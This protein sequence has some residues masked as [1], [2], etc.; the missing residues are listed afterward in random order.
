MTFVN[1]FELTNIAVILC[2]ESSMKRK[3]L[4]PDFFDRPTLVVAKEL[5]GKFLVRRISGKEMALMIT[6]TESY[7][8][9]K[10]RASKGSR[11]QTAGNAPMFAKAG[12]I[13]VYFTYGMH[14]MLN[15]AT[16]EEGYPGAVLIRGGM[17]LH[18][19]KQ[20]QIYSGILEN[21]RI[22]GPARLTKK[23]QI[24]KRLNA[25]TLHKKVGLWIEDRGVI[26]PSRDIQRTPRIGIDSAGSPWVEKKYR[27]VL[28][29]PS[30][31]LRVKKKGPSLRTGPF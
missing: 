9:Y 16:R 7:D 2:A 25:L 22:D 17:L 19:H 8:G 1:S 12:T 15:V 13:Y 28:K 26:I 6:E 31:K 3:I 5:I 20:D 4:G 23:L 18:L 24:D 11:G 21:L 10:D 14:W 27:L 29:N 30:T